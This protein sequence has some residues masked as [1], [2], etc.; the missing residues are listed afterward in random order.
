MFHFL[1]FF[2]KKQNE[3]W[4][5]LVHIIQQ[6]QKTFSYHD[7]ELVRITVNHHGLQK[8]LIVAFVKLR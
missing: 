8:L 6:K 7:D 5:N 1:V 4:K 3:F 2:I